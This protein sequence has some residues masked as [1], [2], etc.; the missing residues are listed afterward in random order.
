[1]N[2]NILGYKFGHLKSNKRAWLQP[3]PRD[4][5]PTNYNNVMVNSQPLKDLWHR[6]SQNNAEWKHQSAACRQKGYTD[7]Y[8]PRNGNDCTMCLRHVTL[9]D[10][11]H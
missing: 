9:Y 6:K 3:S 4:K 10:D 1:M 5:K 8:K 7:L 2:E 11:A